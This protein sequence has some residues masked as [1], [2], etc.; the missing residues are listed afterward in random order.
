M[1]NFFR[2]PTVFHSIDGPNIIPNEIINTA[3]GEGQI[4]YSFT[5]RGQI[6]CLF[7]LEPD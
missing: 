6:P 1:N 2:Y 3:L 7:T 5:L 4:P